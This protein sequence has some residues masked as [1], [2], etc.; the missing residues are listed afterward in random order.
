[1]QRFTWRRINP[2]QQA[3]LDFFLIS[4]NLLSYVKDA[5]IL[6]GYRSD[7]SLITL[8]LC[9]SKETKPRGIWK[10]NSSLLKDIEYIQ[11]INH[12]I[13]NVA[14]EYAAFLYNREN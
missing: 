5:D 2:K 14:A 9:F 3:R 11:L 4:E 1:M 8:E 12:T 6:Y 13:D 7:H 10:F